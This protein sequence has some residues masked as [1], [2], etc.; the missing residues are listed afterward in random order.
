VKSTISPAVVYF[1][2]DLYGYAT[3]SQLLVDGG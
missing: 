2:S 1:A 3:G